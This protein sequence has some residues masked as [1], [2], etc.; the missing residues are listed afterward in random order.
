MTPARLSTILRALRWSNRTAAS[1]IGCSE[2]LIRRWRGGAVPV[3]A[4]VAAWLE[5]VAAGIEAQPAPS[6]TPPA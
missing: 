5:H 3:P 4:N 6:V 2:G 1:L